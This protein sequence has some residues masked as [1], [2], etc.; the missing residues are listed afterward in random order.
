VDDRGEATRCASLRLASKSDVVLTSSVVAVSSAGFGAPAGGGLSHVT[1]AEAQG[2]T[3]TVLDPRRRPEWRGTGIEPGTTD[4]QVVLLTTAAISPW[5]RDGSACNPGDEGY[6]SGRG[7][8]VPRIFAL[9]APS[10]FARDAVLRRRPRAA[11]AQGRSATK[12]AGRLRAPGAIIRAAGASPA[13]V[14]STPV[15]GASLVPAARVSRSRR[16]A[17]RQRRLA[18][19]RQRAV[20]DVLDRVPG[21][22]SSRW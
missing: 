14:G 8:R 1:K 21:A 4:F 22:R 13:I 11:P 20:V 3:A 5:S 15:G 6:R 16:R 7:G 2:D 19:A 9:S 18:A 12:G 17:D 10:P